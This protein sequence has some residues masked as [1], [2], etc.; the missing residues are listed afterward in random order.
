LSVIKIGTDGGTTSGVNHGPE[1]SSMDAPTSPS[2]DGGDLSMMN[3]RLQA[4]IFSYN[5]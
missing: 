4:S 1:T 3:L 2:D 5:K